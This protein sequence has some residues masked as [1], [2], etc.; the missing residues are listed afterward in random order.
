MS[1]N[2]YSNLSITFFLWEEGGY[3]KKQALGNVERKVDGPK[4]R[5]LVCH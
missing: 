5:K 3:G 4:E 2:I 1:Y